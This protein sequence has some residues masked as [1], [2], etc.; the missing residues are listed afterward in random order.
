M[1]ESWGYAVSLIDEADSQGGF[2]TAVAASD[3][4]YITEDVSSGTVG[5]K[6][7][8]APIGVVTE[9]DNLSDEF[10]LSA[11]IAWE[12]GTAV[13][14]NDNTHYITSPFPTGALTIMTST[15]SLA[16]LTGALSPDLDT[17]ASSA[18]GFGI[19][20]LDAG[21][22][23]HAGGSTAGRR[24]QLP[25]GGDNFDLSHLNAD[26]RTILQRAIEWAEAAVTPAVYKILLVVVDPASLTAQEAAKKTLIES[27]GYTVNLIDDSDS[28]ANF[29]AALAASDVAYISSEVVTSTLGNKLTAAT[30]GVVNENRTV[31]ANLGLVADSFDAVTGSSLV[32]ED[33][34]HFI[35][36]QFSLGA[37]TILTGSDQLHAKDDDLAPDIVGLG[38][39]TGSPSY[40]ELAVIDPGGTLWGGG[41]A[42]GRRVQLPWGDSAFDV[43]TLTADGRKLMQRAIEWGATLPAPPLPIAHWKLDEASGTTAEDSVGGN[44]GQLNGNA[45]WITGE[46]GGGLAFDYADGQDYIE[47]PNSSGLEN[48][49]EGDYTLMAWFRPDSTPPGSGSDN[50]AK[51]GILIKAGWHTGISFTNDNRFAFEQVLDDNT[52]LSAISTNS[53][54]PGDFYHV[55][56]VIDRSAGTQSLYVNGQLEGTRSFTPGAAAR[57]YG[58]ESW[59]IGVANPYSSTWGWQADGVIDDV[60]IYDRALNIT[61]IA[62]IAAGGGGGGGGGGSPT[63][64][65][66]RVATGNDDAEERLSNGNVNLT[67]TDLELISDGSNAQLVGMRFTGVAV[68]NGA[69]ITNAWIQFQVDETNTGATNVNIQGEASDSALQFTTANSNISSRG[70]TTASIPWDPVSWTTVGEAGPDQQTPDISAAIQEIVSRPGWAS[71]N[72]MVMIITGSGERTA[73]SYDGSSTGA[74]LLHIEY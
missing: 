38:S 17:L 35:T 61:E 5:T 54:S 60:R 2:D 36:E 46:I 63:I 31:A 51:Y 7:V 72:D 56:G 68:P 26:G 1:F 28:Q 62:D 43:D 23:T 47:I 58:T 30:V 14:I 16:Y 18:S 24:V 34:T 12:T 52:G 55:A 8:S 21:A 70:R 20:T 29:N 59:K 33:N 6:L 66:A 57:E 10:G 69:T 74:P 15:E 13:T 50:D 40:L 41:A 32:I 71:G 44:D 49:Q 45:N 3:V 22:A 25:W 19:V 39:Q 42:A 9:E 64:V 53:F 73:E 27:W 37:L 4:V 48:V 67:S 11:G 65:E